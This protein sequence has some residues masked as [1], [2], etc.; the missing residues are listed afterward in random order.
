M[1]EGYKHNCYSADSLWHEIR[2]LIIEAFHL[3]TLNVY[4]KLINVLAHYQCAA[5]VVYKQFSSEINE[6]SAQSKDI[7][8]I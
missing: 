1:V 8:T 7:K 5:L 2:H 4:Y 3:Y 6:T